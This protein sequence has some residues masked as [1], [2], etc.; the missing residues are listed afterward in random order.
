MLRHVNLPFMSYLFDLPRPNVIEVLKAIERNEI[1]KFTHEKVEFSW[2]REAVLN[3]IQ[4]N[5]VFFNCNRN[6]LTQ[7]EY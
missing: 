6:R 3:D 2:I 4:L 7:D 5:D 1:N